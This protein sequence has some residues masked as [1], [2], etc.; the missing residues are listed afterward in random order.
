MNK[1]T[2]LTADEKELIMGMLGAQSVNAMHPEAAKFVAQ[3]QSIVS[4]LDA[5]TET[6]K[7]EVKNDGK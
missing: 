3:V 4:K 5:L 6:P 2:L 1:Q 7:K